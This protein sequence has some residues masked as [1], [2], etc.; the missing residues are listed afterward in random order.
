MTRWAVILTVVAACGRAA[1]TSAPA[2]PPTEARVRDRTADP[3]LVQLHV[4]G[5][6]PA[7]PPLTY[8]AVDVVIINTSSAPR[9][10]LLPRVAGGGPRAGGVDTLEREAWGPVT[11][12]SWLGTGGFRAVRVGADAR[13][14]LDAMPVQWWRHD[15]D[16]QPPLEAWAAAEVMV[17]GRAL[18]TWLP[19]DPTVAAPG[20]GGPL[21]GVV[22][23]TPA[24]PDHGEV[25][26]E[27]IGPAPVSPVPWPRD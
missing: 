19:A 24:R 17:G 26:V 16:P 3:V 5:E 27:L 9:W 1:P 12:A 10:V 14:Q 13:V 2:A 7:T 6:R 4:T 22:A 25:A 15:D 8:L 20:D 18:A 23:T 21:S 11:V